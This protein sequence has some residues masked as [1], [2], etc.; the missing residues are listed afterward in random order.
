MI[1]EGE[2]EGTVHVGQHHLKRTAAGKGGRE[3]G[4]SK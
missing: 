3:S 1:T 2:S 4:P